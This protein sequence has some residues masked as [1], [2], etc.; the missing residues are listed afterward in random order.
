MAENGNFDADSDADADADVP[1]SPWSGPRLLVPVTLQALVVTEQY[2][3]VL[4][5]W[6]ILQTNYTNLQGYKTP[7]DPLPC[8]NGQLLAPQGPTGAVWTGIVLHWTLPD[9]LRHGTQAA[10]SPLS[11][12]VAASSPAGGGEIVYPLIPNRWL[13][14]RTYQSPGGPPNV[15]SNRVTK[16]WVLESDDLNTTA[17]TNSP[18]SQPN[19]WIQSTQTPAY[20]GQSYTLD[21]WLQNWPA[22]QLSPPQSVPLTAVGVGD[23]TY[24]A[25][26]ANIS[27]VLSFQDDMSDLPGPFSNNSYVPLTYMVFGWYSDPTA[28]PLYNADES[29]WGELMTGLNWAVDDP[30][31]YPNQI[32]CHAMTY[33]VKWYGPDG[34]TQSG[35][36]S[37]TSSTPFIPMVAVGNTSVE[38]LAALIEQ[39]V[40]EK[41]KQSP[42]AGEQ[43]AEIMEA[44]Q[45]N[46][47]QLWDQPGGQVLV[48][49][50][51]HQACF[52]SGPGGTIWEVIAPQNN[53]QSP[54]IS[55]PQTGQTQPLLT[56]EQASLLE[57]LNA[58]QKELDRQQRILSSMQW[59]LYAFWWLNWAFFPSQTGSRVAAYLKTLQPSVQNQVNEVNAIIYGDGGV[60]GLQSIQ[61]QLTA[62]LGD[63]L[64]L[65]SAE[66]P[67]FW[68]PV[69]PVVL[70][71]GAKGSFKHGPDARL[72]PDG[73]L[74]CR[75]TGE[76][77]TNITVTEGSKP[78]QATVSAQ[79]LNPNLD[80]PNSMPAVPPALTDLFN[81][82]TALFGEAMLLDTTEAGMIAQLA[83]PNL[84]PP[85]SSITFA[86]LVQDIQNQ[87]TCFW[88]SIVYPSI[89]QNVAATATGFDGDI[90]YVISI[91][92][93]SPPWSPLYM[94]WQITWYP[95]YYY[96][97]NP[98]AAPSPPQNPA[99]PLSG[100]DYGELDYSWNNSA[101]PD[102]LP[103]YILQG[104]TLL[105]PQATDVFVARLEEL[106]NGMGQSIGTGGEP[107]SPLTDP[108]YG[109]SPPPDVAAALGEVLQI[110]SQWDMLSQNLS[111]FHYQLIQQDTGQHIQCTDPVTGPLVGTGDHAI[112]IYNN[113][114]GQA[115]IGYNPIR[116]GH[117]KL[118]QLWIVDD[119]GQ[120]FNIGEALTNQP[121]QPFSPTAV[122]DWL[123]TPGVQN[124]TMMQ[125]PPRVVQPTRLSFSLVSAEDDSLETA[126]V[127]DANP[128]CGWVLPNHLDN[129]LAIYDASGAALGELQL[130]GGKNNQRARWNAAPDSPAPVGAPPAIANAHLR[131]FVEGVLS[132]PDGGG[133]ALGQLLDVIDETLWTID[134]L[135][136]RTDQSL[137]VLIGRPLALVR[138]SVAFEIAGQPVYDKSLYEMSTAYQ[139]QA[140]NFQ[141]TGGFT[142]VSFTV[143]LGSLELPGD[144]LLGYFLG[145]NYLQFNS[146][147]QPDTD[148]QPPPYVVQNNLQLQLNTDLTSPPTGTDLSSPIGESAAYI[149]MLVDPRGSVHASTG[150]LPV[151]EISLPSYYVQ[152]ALA[153]MEV[154][155][156]TGPLL[157]VTEQLQMPLPASSQGDWTWI[158][159]PSVTVWQETTD[160]TKAS[161]QAILSDIPLSVREGWL[162]LSGALGEDDK[163]S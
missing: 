71:C 143:E 66:A 20:L 136:G 161:P 1:G 41:M 33:D 35:V 36:P 80:A 16:S 144:G 102:A 147:H 43:V 21:Q 6:S 122:S 83:M 82:I 100:W 88:N 2:M 78:S 151:Q 142:Q 154:T 163:N 65:V 54:P 61:A 131:S 17:P 105:T 14:V 72:N 149:T 56:P 60:A 158:Q 123:T 74:P 70:I 77:I 12:G 67:R 49:Q 45:Y 27:N 153:Q 133:P 148:E 48:D 111:G 62:A 79:A 115:L 23:A 116:A 58:L 5:N 59:E 96:V 76:T 37:V 112:P 146:V 55:P 152:P 9:S 157:T 81:N 85:D 11:N 15:P 18:L 106:L 121:A 29:N 22:E 57:Q 145:D 130:V 46:L 107:A 110:V 95:S 109:Y 24:P 73:T 138:A 7:V 135:G 31:G 124:P 128:V 8:Q 93:W 13:V 160:L 25:Y 94:D 47:I 90:P 126:Y 104:R 150:I 64:Q 89:D 125:L 162:K 113:G 127:P 137:S 119:F 117:F 75:V 87:Q 4:S 42:A 40:V 120:V 140:A 34:P 53:N 101:Q 134:P 139:K 155:F 132:R 51:R 63:S 3:N 99:F 118:N 26:I 68:Q 86:A 129:S 50:Q 141:N 19:F 44:F 84:N 103:G 156:Q 28:D 39:Q 38:A 97:V 91:A 52:G 69:D 114:T 30:Q 92:P 159:Q 108:T 98:A 10:A 32:L